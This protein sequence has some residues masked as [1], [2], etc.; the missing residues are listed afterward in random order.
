L[1]SDVPQFMARSEVFGLFRYDLCTEITA[2]NLAATRVWTKFTTCLTKY[3]AG[4]AF[5]CIGL[6]S[7]SSFID[8]G[9]NTGEFALQLCRRN[10]AAT[11]TVV[12]LPVV[13]KL[14]RQHIGAVAGA[15]VAGRI[16]FFPSDMRTGPLP[17]AA[18]LVCFKS[19]L[20]DWPD[21]DAVQL[22][23]RAHALVR[24]GGR[25]IIFERAPIDIHG[26]RVPYAMAPDLV[27][28]NFF[29]AA[30]IYLEKLAALGFRPIEYRRIAL[31][32]GFHLIIAGR[33]A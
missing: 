32:V 15:D 9:G 8:L 10:A 33:P 24:P 31:D 23:E 17:A 21:A 25:L 19:V 13:C 27:F 6:D 5:D 26:R 1:L 20:H 16:A 14:G 4:P 11:A 22:L 18:D 3:E 12:D 28:L 29:R 2:E 30:E 7:V